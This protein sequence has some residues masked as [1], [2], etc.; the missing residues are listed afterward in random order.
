MDT[1]LVSVI[2]PIMN[3]AK[4]IERALKS[5]F[6]Q[7]Y[8]NIEIIVVD[9]GSV[10]EI[11][12][13]INEIRNKSPFQIIYLKQK[14]TGP[15]IARSNG[16]KR[17]K[18]KYIQYL[19]SD[20]ELL[21][22]KIEKQVEVLEK[23]PDVVMVYGN[24]IQN[25][26]EKRVHRRKHIK[27]KVDDL[28][29]C[30]LEKRKWHTSACLWNY[31]KIDEFWDDLRNG[32][33]VL[34]DV[35]VGIKV[36]KK[37]RFIEEVVCNINFNSNDSSHLSNYGSDE[38][39]IKQIIDNAS[40]LNNSSYKRLLGAGLK[41]EEYLEPLAERYFYEA[42]K[43]SKYKYLPE[44]ILMLKTGINI[45]NSYFKKAEFAIAI[46]IINNFNNNFVLIKS[47]FK[48]HTWIMPA[49]VHQYRKLHTTLLFILYCS[50]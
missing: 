39:R 8:K 29:Q 33:D 34:H 45:T 35:T 49:K 20:D 16:L 1:P 13:K 44:A 30:A 5:V 10:D 28:I 17:S 40:K 46:F 36:G 27:Y 42:L 19:D 24:S 32:E 7:T 31:G 26:D 2:I 9:D 47:L 18:G 12:E 14:N 37:I 23:D 15:G 50:I 25:W 41:K 38:K 11:D 43:F 22:L 21:P 3:R 4:I 6:N 48:I